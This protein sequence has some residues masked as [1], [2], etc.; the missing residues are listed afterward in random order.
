MLTP[1]EH[2]PKSFLTVAPTD[3][4]ALVP[5]LSLIHLRGNRQ[6]AL[7]VSVLLHGNETT[8][9]LAIQNL[10]KRYTDKPLPR[11][12]ILLVGNVTA[13]REG[14]RH[15]ASQ[16]DFNRIWPVDGQPSGE[17]DL[18]QQAQAV[19][20]YVQHHGIFAAVDVHNNTGRNPHYACIT[21]TEPQFLQLANLF[22]QLIVHFTH[23]RTLLAAAFANLAPSTVLECGQPNLDHG[24]QHAAD[25][26]DAC[27]HLTALTDHVLPQDISLYHTVATVKIPP[28][29]RFSF[30]N[31]PNPTC[32]LTF[33][34]DLDRFN[35]SELEPGTPFAMLQG[36]EIPL[37]VYCEGTTDVRDRYFS[38]NPPYLEISQAVMP[39]MLTLDPNIIEQDCLCY[40]MK[41]IEL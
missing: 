39:A 37:E 41:R 31:Q 33:A 9:I 23:P 12:L 13:A 22:G 5:D 34:T 25:Y 3:I 14:Q 38:I 17:S 11:D 26:L 2:L 19:F 7:F 16:P 15:L 40:F 30:G 10:L 18:H 21:R 27:L 24:T 32:D 20:Q 8:G 35:F 28:H 4:H 1:L 6:P 29:V 36:T